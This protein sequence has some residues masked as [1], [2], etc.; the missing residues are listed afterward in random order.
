MSGH[1]DSFSLVI[2]KDTIFDYDF[3]V[4]NDYIEENWDVGFSTLNISIFGYDNDPRE[5]YEIPEV[6]KWVK[7]SINEEKIPWFYILANDNTSSS[8]KLLALCY[9]TKE[10]KSG[11]TKYQ[12]DAG[13]LREFAYINFVNMNKYVKSKKISENIVIEISEKISNYLHNWVDGR[14]EDNMDEESTLYGRQKY[15][16]ISY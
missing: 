4:I 5:L 14:S 8:I 13:K 16:F 6:I 2:D 1:F 15:V 12:L 11:K 7:Y 10:T 9:C 3:S